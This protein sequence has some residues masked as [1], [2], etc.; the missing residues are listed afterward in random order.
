M[1]ASKKRALINRAR[2][3]EQL[4][5]SPYTIIAPVTTKARRS[6]YKFTHQRIP[7][8]KHF[9]VHVPSKNHRARIVKGNLSIRGTF[10]G[11]VSTETRYFL[12]PRAPRSMDHIVEMTELML[13][14]MPEGF[15]SILTGLLG[16]TGEPAQKGTLVTRIRDYWYGYGEKGMQFVGYRFMSSRL[17]G[18][19]VQ[20]GRFVDQRRE[21]QREINR[22]RQE[23]WLTPGEKQERGERAKKLQ[24]KLK[25]SK[26]AK[27][28]ARTRARNKRHKARSHK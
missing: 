22:Q 10:T 18:A 8:A 11:G 7:R 21:R 25:R 26:A 9:I 24:Q 6:L 3:F 5:S 28:A 4:L 12:F 17:E 15:Y 2:K 1:S 13:P 16:D 27:K 23:G 20:R 14:E 19:E